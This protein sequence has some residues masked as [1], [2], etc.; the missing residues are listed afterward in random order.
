MVFSYE[1][2]RYIVGAM[3]HDECDYILQ[4]VDSKLGFSTLSNNNIVDNTV[5]LSE[6]CAININDDK[7]IYNIVSRHV[8]DVQKCENLVV[9]K[10]KEGGF[11][12]PHYDASKYQKNKREYTIIFGLNDCDEYEG[13]ETIFPLMNRGFR[14]KKGDALTFKNI[15]SNDQIPEEYLHGGA[16]VTKG[17]KMICT[18]WVRKEK[19]L[20]RDE[21]GD[22]IYSKSDYEFSSIAKSD[23]NEVE[24]LEKSVYI[25]DQER[26]NANCLQKLINGCPDL[27]LVVKLK[28]RIIA[29]MYGGLIDGIEL[30]DEKINGIHDPSGDTLT[31]HSMSVAREFSRKGFGDFVARYYYNEWLTKSTFKIKYYSVATRPIY[32]SWM[33]KLGFAL[34]GPSKISYGTE[35]W[36]D[37]FKIA[38]T[39]T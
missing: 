6:D 18:L 4:L 20:D 29:T 25:N 10:Y 12:K 19:I 11:Y 9:L 30:T 17:V 5:R 24:E 36:L 37:F 26:P 15:D 3:S 28:G 14:M 33:K 1:I 34:I 27:T 39:Q 22:S 31:I 35:Y 21:I 13:G 38:P 23:I 8:D 2:P 16:M 32:E 7:K